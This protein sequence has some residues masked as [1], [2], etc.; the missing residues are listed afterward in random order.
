MEKLQLIVPLGLDSKSYL[1]CC[2]QGNRVPVK[3]VRALK[4]RGLG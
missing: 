1:R 2:C 3:L 4:A